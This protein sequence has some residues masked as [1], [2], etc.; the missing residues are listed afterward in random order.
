MQL[1]SE[2]CCAGILCELGLF[3][4]RFCP[5][6]WIGA[7]TLFVIVGVIEV[8]RGGFDSTTKDQLVSLRFPAFYGCGVVLLVLG[9]IGSWLAG[10]SGELPVSRWLSSMVLLAIVLALMAMDHVFIYQ[11]LVRMVTPPGRSKPAV[12]VQ[13]HEASKF[14]NLVELLFCLAAAG[15]MN[16]PVKHRPAEGR[17][18][19]TR[20]QVND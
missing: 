8:T 16:W 14:V 9:L 3:L 18:L 4:A 7:A 10:R 15:L 5:S 2:K 11:P 6:A 12:F 1:R 20:N 13:Y 19:E 17:E